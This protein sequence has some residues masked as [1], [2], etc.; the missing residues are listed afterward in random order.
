MSL[1]PRLIRESFALVEDRSDKVASHF[2]A[3]LFLDSPGLRDMF[4]PMM[5]TQRDRL[6][7]ALV[8]VVHRL[9]DADALVEYL[10]QLG[11]DHRKF[12]V[13]PE[14]YDAVGRCLLAA[15]RHYAGSDWTAAMDEAWAAAFAIVAE[16]MI[17]AAD[18]ASHSTPPWWTG[19]VVRHRQ[20]TRTI[21]EITIEPDQRFPFR[22]GQYASIET[23]RWP[24]VW[25]PY[26][27]ANA[28]RPDNQLIFQVRAIDGGWVSSALVHHTQVGDPLRLG[29][30][31]GAMNIDQES[32]R[33]V[34]LVGGGTGIAPIIAMAED[35]ARWNSSRRVCIFYGARR[36]EELYALP[37][38]NRLAERCSWMTVV[39]CVS[40]EPRFLG[41]CGL[42]PDVLTRLGAYDDNWTQHEVYLSGSAAMVRATLARLVELEVPMR[43]IRF[44][45]I[46]EE[47]DIY[48]GLKRHRRDGRAAG[49]VL[50]RGPEAG[51]RPE[52]GA[53]G[54]VRASAD[55]D[56]DDG[57]GFN[58]PLPSRASRAGREPGGPAQASK[59]S[60][61]SAQVGSDWQVSTNPSVFSSGSRA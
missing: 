17:V 22:P 59:S 60:E 55:A 15:M 50:T 34:L 18:D 36:P 19:Y 26:S 23:Q 49:G 24:R 43:Q 41:E 52:S 2:Y 53:R 32:E 3:L 29:P 16:T 9:E 11:R 42:L 39:P 35:M 12:G 37:I 46:G 44:D 48:L 56:F 27:I 4:P 30:A 40:H 47:T 21:A 6:V 13:R 25:R 58:D 51:Y 33:N 38:L 20:P 45:A 61:T 8:K 5:D 57:P 14:H 54:S 28:P 31:M 1:D 10:R 7:G